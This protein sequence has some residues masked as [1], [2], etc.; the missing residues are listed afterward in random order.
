V[1]LL[2]DTHALLWFL[3]GDARLSTGA[4]DAIEDLA[5]TRFFSIASAWEVAIKASLGKLVLSAP[6]NQL[7]PGQL[8]ANGIELLA[9]RPDHIAELLTLPFHHR[10]PFDRILITQAAVENAVVVSADATL[11]RYGIN[12]LW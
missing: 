12:R 2:L 7:I 3:A 4:R 9:I 8:R 6:F 1:N 10:D 11:D 5:N